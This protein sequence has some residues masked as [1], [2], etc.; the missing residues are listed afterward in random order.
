MSLSAGG[1]GNSTHRITSER[2]D[3]L[4]H[5]VNS[6]PLIL[7]RKI[8]LLAIAKAE[9]IQAIVYRDKYHWLS[10]FDRIRHEFD[11]VFSQCVSFARLEKKRVG[12]T[13]DFRSGRTE[14]DYLR[15]SYIIVRNDWIQWCFVH[16]VN[17]DKNRTWLLGQ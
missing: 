3:V 1:S 6:K 5:P 12:L 13:A 8:L 15:A 2:C 4:S 7:K 17:P 10:S 14:S 16:T 9:D 11:G